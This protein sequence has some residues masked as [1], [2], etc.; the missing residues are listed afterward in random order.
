MID[1][2]NLVRHDLTADL[3]ASFVEAGKVAWDIET[4][5][6]DWRQGRIGTC[7]L[8]AANTGTVLVQIDGD[9][10]DRLA[11]L[12]ADETVLKVFHHAPFDL[13]WMTSHWQ[14]KPASI[15]CTKVASRLL[16]P[17]GGS[18]L[19]SLK[20]LLEQDLGVHLDKAE[21]LSDWTVESLTPAQLEYAARDVEYLVPLLDALTQRL[22]KAG[23][24]TTYKQCLSYLP[25]RILFDVNN[26]PDVFSY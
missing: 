11:A 4:T 21:R 5:G 2:G 23:L 22:A 15:A 17:A 16:N 3:A 25:T 18:E 10:P 13:R 9:R 26:W 1:T 6:L 24:L 8:H 7:Q 20:H 19:H 12:L 14:T